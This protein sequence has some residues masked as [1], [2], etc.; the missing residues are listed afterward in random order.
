MTSPT[1][2]TLGFVV[3]SEAPGGGGEEEGGRMWPDVDTLTPA[4]ARLS[5]WV[6]GDLQGQWFE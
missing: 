2:N 1:A 5:D 3:A 6:N 4:A